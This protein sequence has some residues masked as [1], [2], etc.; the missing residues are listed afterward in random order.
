MVIGFIGSGK[1]GFSLGKYFSLKGIT[2]SGYYSKCYKDAIE[3]SEFTSSKAY[4]NINDLVKDSSVIFITTPDDS[5]NEVWQK[6]S[7]INLTNKIIC[8]T[9]GSLTSS[10]FLNINNSDAL[11]YSIHPI[12]AFSDKYNSYKDLQNAYFSIEGPE[13]H[14]HLLKDFIDSLGNKSFVIDKNNKA[15]YHLA[16]VTVSNLVLSLINT[17]CS[18]LS[19]CGLSENDALEALLPLIQNNINN[20]KESGIISALTGPIERNDLDTIRHHMCAIP[21]GDAQLY[22]NL[23]LK[24]LPLSEKKHKDKDYTKLKEYLGMQ[25]D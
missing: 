3:A 9:S 5:I 17:G 12:F 13:S 24:L 16:S 18:Y 14:I 8:H 6:I 22:K 15:L 7:N 19:K 4:E 20:I 11:A 21:T 10:I 23:S 25:E 2:L 1:V